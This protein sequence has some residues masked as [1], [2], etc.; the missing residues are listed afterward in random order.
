MWVMRAA[1]VLALSVVI[2]GLVHIGSLLGVPRVATAGPYERLAGL[3]AEGRFA[4]L[5][6]EDASADMLPFRDPAF[7]TAACRYDLSGGPVVMRAE[8]PTTY[9]ALAIHTRF[10]QPFYL[11][12][13]KAAREGAVEVKIFS[14]EQ[15]AAAEAEAAAPDAAPQLRIVSPTRE[16]FALV[17]LFVNGESARQSMRD[18]AGK[19]RCGPA[20]KISS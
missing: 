12:T 3:G 4:A 9:G 15:E 8:L 18:V 6:D 10:G 5:P 19:A 13:D 1:Y 16:G 20:P 17:R 7:V 11:L 14:S 2:A